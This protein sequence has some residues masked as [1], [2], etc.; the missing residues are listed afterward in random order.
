MT[1]PQGF[2]DLEE[3]AFFEQLQRERR[4]WQRERTRMQLVIE[5]QQ[6]DLSKRSGAV[7]SRA[8]EIA[9]TFSDGIAS[10]EQ[11]T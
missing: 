7:E 1:L 9:V 6:Q 5:L 11:V 8:A 4:E 3:E 10:F 2:D